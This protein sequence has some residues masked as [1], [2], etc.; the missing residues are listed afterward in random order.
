MYRVGQI[1][2]DSRTPVLNS[3]N[4]Y[5]RRF[6]LREAA[7]H[8]DFLFH[9]CYI[10]LCLIWAISLLTYLLT[11][12]RNMCVR[13]WWSISLLSRCI[14]DPS[15][16]ISTRF[17]VVKRFFDIIDL[18]DVFRKVLSD[19]YVAWREI[20]ALCGIAVG[21]CFGFLMCVWH[22]RSGM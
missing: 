8:C 3:P 2:L 18:D 5:R 21:K 15:F 12:L 14:P 13:V 20:V 4:D 19:V 16:L 1:S 7:T 17:K 10:Y 22:I 6:C 9:L 11:Y